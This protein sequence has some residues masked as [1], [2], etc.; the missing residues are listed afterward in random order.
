MSL[1][2]TLTALLALSIACSGGEE[3]TPEGTTPPPPPEEVKEVPTDAAAA[4][5][6]ATAEEDE[7]EVEYETKKVSDVVKVAFKEKRNLKKEGTKLLQNSAVSDG[8][9]EVVKVKMDKPNCD[10]TW[11][12][13]K[14]TGTARRV[15][16]APKEEA[17]AEEGAAEGE[18]ATE[19]DAAEKS[20]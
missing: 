2:L 13:A 10:D 3:A 12:T 8:Y 7:P 11:C 6:A 4:A 17:A 16:E 18:A 15:K 1:R 5:A 9:T 19:A 20:E 14:V